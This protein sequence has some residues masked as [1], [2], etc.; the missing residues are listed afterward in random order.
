VAADEPD[1]LEDPNMHFLRKKNEIIKKKI[2]TG[3]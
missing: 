1:A 3:N 2:V